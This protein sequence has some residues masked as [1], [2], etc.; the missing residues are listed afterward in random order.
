LAYDLLSDDGV[1]VMNIISAVE[2]KSGGVFRGIYAAFSE[3]FPHTRVFLATYPHASTVRQN[4][5]LVAS[6]NELSNDK[7]A[8]ENHKRLLSHEL[9]Q[10]VT[11]DISA[12]RDSFA[13]VEYYSIL[14]R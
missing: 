13:P 4:V 12:F 10:P 14:M 11:M 5:M 3:V 9:K 7:T 8:G 1:T 6:K 2:G